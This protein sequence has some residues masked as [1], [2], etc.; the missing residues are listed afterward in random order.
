MSRRIDPTG[1]LVRRILTCSWR[2]DPS[3]V[4]FSQEEL[5]AA[6]PMLLG[7][8]AGALTWWKIRNSSLGAHPAAAEFRQAYRHNSISA[9]VREIEI[10]EVFALFRSNGIEPL[11]IKGWSAARPYPEPG[12]RPYGDIDLVVQDQD[13][14]KAVEVH[15]SL[16]VKKFNIDL[17]HSEITALDSRSIADF[18]ARSQ[19]VSLGGSEI[20]VLSPEDHLRVICIHTLKHGVWRPLWLC[21]IAAAIESAPADFDWDYCLGPNNR[22]RRWILSAVLLS[23]ELLGAYL[24]NTPAVTLPSKQ[25]GWLIPTILKQWAEPY[26]AIQEYNR[27]R[28]PMISYLRNPKG[29]ITDLRNRW[30][31]PIAATID[32]G[33]Q[34]NGLPR[35]PFQAGNC[36]VR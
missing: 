17:E 27:H 10:K 2:Q 35:L 4:S 26:P 23:G 6:L 32:L 34:L 12:L 8:G 19:V 11:M 14:K 28:A 36:V 25:P 1:D 16:G 18:F 31:N 22:Q 7:S 24:K 9:A 33:G 20:R 29:L 30:P 3:P 13:Y 5:T 21:D 15:K